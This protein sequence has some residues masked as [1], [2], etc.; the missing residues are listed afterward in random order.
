MSYNPNALGTMFPLSLYGGGNSPA[1]GLPDRP[2]RPLLG[3]LMGQDGAQ[4]PIASATNGQR[5]FQTLPQQAPDS[6]SP[7][8]PMQDTNP[9][10]AGGMPNSGEV[11]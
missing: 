2:R 10:I 7:M 3:E 8:Q 9:L 1:M 5:P 11:P 4:L 6:P